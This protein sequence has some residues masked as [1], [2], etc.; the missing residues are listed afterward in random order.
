[1]HSYIRHVLIF[2]PFQTLVVHIWYIFVYDFSVVQTHLT[3]TCLHIVS[4]R[5]L[6]TRYVTF[7]FLLK[8]PFFLVLITGFFETVRSV[9]LFSFSKSIRKQ[10]LLD[11]IRFGNQ[12]RY[13]GGDPKSKL[14]FQLYIVVTSVCNICS[15]V[16]RERRYLCEALPSR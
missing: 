14:N 9:V 11:D 5:R 7:F 16:T 4:L 15:G 2:R 1:M 6:V 13:T 3:Y 12:T 8:N 10:K